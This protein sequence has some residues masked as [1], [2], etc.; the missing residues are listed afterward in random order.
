[1]IR[2]VLLRSEIS[3]DHIKDDDIYEYHPIPLTK[4]IKVWYRMIDF[5]AN[6][7]SLKYKGQRYADQLKFIDAFT[8]TS[9]L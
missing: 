2:Y 6:P 8:L 4:K 1:M 7:V 5:F 3:K 9:A